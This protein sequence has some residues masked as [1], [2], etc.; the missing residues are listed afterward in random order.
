[1][2]IIHNRRLIEVKAAEGVNVAEAHHTEAFQN[3]LATVNT[4][5]YDG[6]PLLVYMHKGHPVEVTAD[7]GVDMHEALE[8]SMFKNW[9]ATMD[10][11]NFK[12]AAVR[13]M[14]LYSV[15]I[16]GKKR[17]FF[18]LL[19]SKSFANGNQAPGGVFTSDSSAT[20]LFILKY[21]NKRWAITVRQPRTP[22][23]DVAFEEIV[24]GTLD[25][26]GKI[27]SNMAR[28]IKEELGIDITEGELINLSALAGH[29]R[30]FFPS[31]GR[32]S[33]TIHCYAV[34][35]EV[36]EAVAK[37]L[38]GRETGVKEEGEH[39]RVDV[40]PLD[41]LYKI[42]DGKTHVALGLYERFVWHKR[43]PKSRKSRK[44]A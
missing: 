2:Q 42:P 29:D 5:Q 15:E 40:V 41:D 22:T 35:K 38:R 37:A 34:E 4:D 39:I 44:C 26:E 8:T 24:A 27:V 3:W 17:N 12:V 25:H 30:G 33:E 14:S 28:E 1:M 36:D 31:P 16:K 21:K 9:I 18:L 13:F 6:K 23:G 19:D 11:V 32:C 20:C 10:Q 43:G 7:P